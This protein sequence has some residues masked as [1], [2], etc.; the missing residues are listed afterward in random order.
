MSQAFTVFKL[1]QRMQ[2][3]TKVT[4]DTLHFNIVLNLRERVMLGPN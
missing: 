4:R 1:H 2:P 3:N